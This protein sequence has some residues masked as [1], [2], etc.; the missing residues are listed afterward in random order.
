MWH[1]A[2]VAQRLAGAY[3]GR[4]FANLNLKLALHHREALDRAA[5]MAFGRDLLSAGKPTHTVEPLSLKFRACAW[6][7]ELYP[8]MAIFLA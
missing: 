4:R 7:C 1:I 5:L 6:P 3:F 2:A 8:T